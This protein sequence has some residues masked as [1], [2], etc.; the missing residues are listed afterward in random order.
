C[1]VVGK[2]RKGGGPAR[3][4]D[5]RESESGRLAVDEHGGIIGK[6]PGTSDADG[7][8]LLDGE[9]LPRAMPVSDGVFGGVAER[10]VPDPVI[11]GA[12]EA[13]VGRQRGENRRR[14]G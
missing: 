2:P 6:H 13:I 14:Q 9:E 1:A 8:P 7:G 11:A 3:A 5:L 4:E 10:V 12:A